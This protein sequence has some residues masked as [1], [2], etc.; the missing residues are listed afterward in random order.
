MSSCAT[1]VAHESRNAAPKIAL[2]D[3][4]AVGTGSCTS[5]AKCAQSHVA[6]NVAAA[7]TQRR[8]AITAGSEVR[9]RGMEGLHADELR[10]RRPRR[11]DDEVEATE[12]GAALGVLRGRGRF[13][14]RDAEPAREMDRIEEHPRAEP[15]A[16]IRR[17][18]R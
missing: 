3:R 7:T 10:G 4:M 17:V 11:I 1:S 6:G 2:P 13:E 15:A 9:P 5:P 12:G 16:A 8:S 14:S 18:E